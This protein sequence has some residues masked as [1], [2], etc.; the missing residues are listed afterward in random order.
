MN[1][2]EYSGFKTIQLRGPIGF[3]NS[4][5][6]LKHKY[7]CGCQSVKVVIAGI[8]RKSLQDVFMLPIK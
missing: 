4:N 1:H 2:Y 6:N 8:S 3:Y 5:T 7:I